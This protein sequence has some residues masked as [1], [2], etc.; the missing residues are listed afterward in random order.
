M[1]EGRYEFAQQ[2]S[3]MDETTDAG[4]QAPLTAKYFVRICAGQP[5]AVVL[6]STMRPYGIAV[7]N[8][9]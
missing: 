9:D 1:V 2:Y 3:P 7:V 5:A 4:H 6:L 8:M